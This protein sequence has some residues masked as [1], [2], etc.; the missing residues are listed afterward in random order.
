MLK[1]SFGTLLAVLALGFGSP[2]RLQAQRLSS[3]YRFIEP[4]QDFALSLSYIWADAGKAGIGPQAGPA[5]G[6]RYTRR[7]SRPISITPQVVFFRTE[8]NVID[9]SLEEGQEDDGNGSTFI[10]TEGLDILIVTGRLNLNLTGPRTWHNLAP[11]GFGGIGVA[12]DMSGASNCGSNSS[13]ADCQVRARERFDFGTSLL[14]QLGIGTVWMPG[15][16]LSARFEALNDIWRI[17]T[18]PGY[19]DSQTTIT[20]IPPPS[21]WTNNWELALTLS[22]WF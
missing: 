6:I 1:L 2:C 13:A 20:P 7:V 4:K 10:G 16:R 18:P 17:K 14:L 9:P 12:I 11:Y 19:Y 15:Q 22:Y 5:V 8:R 3:P 21:D